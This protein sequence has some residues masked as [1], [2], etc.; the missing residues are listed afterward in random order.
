MNQECRDDRKTTLICW[1]F[2]TLHASLSI[3]ASGSVC[4]CETDDSTP[5]VCVLWT[6][7]NNLL[8]VNRFG[9]FCFNS[10]FI[11]NHWLLQNN[12][13]VI[14]WNKCVLFLLLV[15][16]PGYSWFWQI[17]LMGNTALFSILL[18]KWCR[19]VRVCLWI[20]ARK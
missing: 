12:S 16:P 14:V 9:H 18:F 6:L 11:L 8:L 13:C 4:V 19:G 15:L 20:Y 7:N 3:E 10:E 5:N 17:N 1:Y 2:F